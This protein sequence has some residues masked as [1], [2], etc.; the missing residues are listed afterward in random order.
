MPCFDCFKSRKKSEVSDS[1][2]EMRRLQQEIAVAYEAKPL[3]ETA[4]AVPD[5]VVTIVNPLT[6]LQA[7]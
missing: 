3:S 2:V 5:S 1:G 7:E 6:K 4:R